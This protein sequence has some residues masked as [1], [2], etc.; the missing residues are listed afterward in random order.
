MGLD[1]IRTRLKTTRLIG[2]N[3]ISGDGPCRTAVIMPQVN[4]VLEM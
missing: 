3:V 2:S 1:W 4:S